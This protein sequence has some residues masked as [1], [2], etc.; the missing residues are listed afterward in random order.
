M[1]VVYFH[2]SDL[3]NAIVQDET[4][5]NIYYCT[6][7]LSISLT[8]KKDKKTARVEQVR[9]FYVDNFMH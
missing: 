6:I 9:D 8:D 7:A 5:I 4:L 2:K 1:I 3:L